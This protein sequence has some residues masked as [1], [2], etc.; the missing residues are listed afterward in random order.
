MGDHRKE[1]GTR[2]RSRALLVAVGLGM[3]LFIAG[4]VLTVTSLSHPD[5]VLADDGQSAMP[6]S[7][8]TGSSLTLMTGLLLS[9]AGLVLATAGPA[10]C[11]IHERMGSA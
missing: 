11:F 4:F 7:A 10:V 9:L 2:L 1:E 8:D 3:V 6:E 5:G